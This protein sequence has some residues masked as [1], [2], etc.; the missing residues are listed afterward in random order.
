[1]SVSTNDKCFDVFIQKGDIAISSDVEILFNKKLSTSH[2]SFL[3]TILRLE[4]FRYGYGRKPKNGKIWNTLIKLPAKDD[5]P[6]WEWMEKYINSL[7][8]SKYL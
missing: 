1:M 4:Q 6:D 2:L 3:A 5:Q 8:Y 7:K